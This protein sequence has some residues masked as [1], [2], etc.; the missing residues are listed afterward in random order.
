M[1]IIIAFVLIAVASASSPTYPTTTSPITTTTPMCPDTWI[2]SL[3]GC[4]LFLY[5]ESLSWREGQAVCE[6]LGGYLAEI[7]S[8]EQQTL[9]EGIALLEEGF[10]GPRFWLIG[11]TDFGHEGR[12]VWQ[13]SVADADFTS[14]APGYPSS[15]DPGD[16]CAVLNFRQGYSWTDVSCEAVYGSPLCMRDLED[17]LTTTP[18]VTTIGSTTDYNYHV[19][20]QGGDGVSTG[21]VFAVNSVG[22][23][24]PVCDDNWS[25]T[26]ADTVCKQLGFEGGTPHANSYFGSVPSKFAMDNVNCS[27][28]DLRIQDCYYTTSENCG[29][30]E[31]AGVSCY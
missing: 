6:G 30:T 12:W 10:T 2:Q 1:R 7:K 15:S 23:F 9:L 18:T 16:D 3:E 21:N 26:E 24:G 25:D 20:L 22:Y 17:D 31:G 5:T 28:S 19:E 14:W 4:F 27:P 29:S 11:L 8:S 13:H